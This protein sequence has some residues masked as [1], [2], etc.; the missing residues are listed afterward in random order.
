MIKIK[1]SI[2]GFGN[3]LCLDQFLGGIG[4]QFGGV[5]FF[6]NEPD[7]DEVDFWFVVD[8]LQKKKERV[9]VNPKHVFFLSAEQIYD[10]GYY[11]TYDKSMFLN[12]LKKSSI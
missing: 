1:L 9:V 11:D 10:Y 5:T 8:N 2:P 12:Q 3:K 6:V 7:V 4:N